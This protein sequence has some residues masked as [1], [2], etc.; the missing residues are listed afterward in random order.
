MTP[1]K[2]LQ[3]ILKVELFESTAP[4]FNHTEALQE[5]KLADQA[6]SL[7]EQFKSLLKVVNRYNDFT[8][9]E[10]K[11]GLLKHSQVLR[12]IKKINRPNTDVRYSDESPVQEVYESTVKQ[13]LNK[14]HG[15]LT[16]N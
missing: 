3:E 11:E 7:G 12:L 9:K 10:I 8:D 4:S 15:Y 6:K 5:L 16:I 1:I 14:R 2:E 13:F